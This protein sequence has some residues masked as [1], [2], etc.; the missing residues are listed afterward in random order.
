MNDD[1]LATV[2]NNFTLILVV[3]AALVFSISVIVTKKSFDH[4][5]E[6]RDMSKQEEKVL[7]TL[8]QNKQNIEGLQDEAKEL[9]NQGFRLDHALSA[10]P[11]R[12]HPVADL[13]AFE[14]LIESSGAD[15][16]NIQVEPAG[17]GMGG[18][19]EVAAEAPPEGDPEGEGLE[20]EGDLGDE[21]L[22]GGDTTGITSYNATI[23]VTGSYSVI[24]DF[25][26]NIETSHK[27]LISE[28]LQLSSDSDSNMSA[29][30]RVVLHHQKG[31]SEEDSLEGGPEEGM[32]EE[33]L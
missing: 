10:L 16:Q 1:Q 4:F 21:S 20:G 19:G 33:D 30:I 26:H 9:E 31:E 28:K 25:L 5:S 7:S 32:I 14:L 8:E 15:L 17:D 27:P 29:E 2:K 3:I 6:Y 24:K 18:G 23:T 22:E 12:Y 11:M 13:A